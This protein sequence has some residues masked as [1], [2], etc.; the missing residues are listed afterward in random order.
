MILTQIV[1]QTQSL[2]GRPLFGIRAPRGCGGFLARWPECVEATVRDRQPSRCCCFEKN[3]WVSEL[4]GD[5]NRQMAHKESEEK[6]GP[7]SANPR[8]R[9]S[10]TLKKGSPGSRLLLLSLHIPVLSTWRLLLSA[11][12]LPAGSLSPSDGQSNPNYNLPDQDSSL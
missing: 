1:E 11:G 3:L 12:R 8:T 5:Y 4:A 9:N 2:Q 10:S 6:N 7:L